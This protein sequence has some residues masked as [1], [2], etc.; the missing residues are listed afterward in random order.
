MRTHDEGTPHKRYLYWANSTVGFRGRRVLEIGGCSPVKQILSFRPASW[1]C[2]NLDVGAVARFNDEVSAL[3]KREF[4]ATL[5]DVNAAD[6]DASFDIVYSINAFEH[7]DALD[8]LL[9][10]IST[11]LSPNG[12]LFTVFGPIWSCDIGHHLSIP[13][14]KGPIGMLDG[15]LEP[16]EHLDRKPNEMLERLI[17]IH[18]PQIANRIVEYV[19]HYPD[20]NRKSEWELY[21]ALENSGLFPSFV[22]RKKTK[23]KGSR[24]YHGKTREF[25][26]VATKKKPMLHEKMSHAAGFLSAFIF[27]KVRPTT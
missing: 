26:W 11:A 19:Y 12:A 22:L 7:I 10:R 8:Q 20:L 5:A 21:S 27:T 16:W 6:F 9:K 17:P 1:T 13:T 25:L 3:G 18:G 23:L 24:E 4:S 15:V 2:I 14:E